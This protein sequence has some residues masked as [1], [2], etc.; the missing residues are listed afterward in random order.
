M[1]VHNFDEAD[2]Q[3]AIPACCEFQTTQEH[4]DHLMLCWG[5][6]VAIEQGRSMDC[7]GCDSAVRPVF[8][9][10]STTV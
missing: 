2:Y 10:R 7:S 9:R 8:F 5:L 1:T 3:A 4:I 6:V